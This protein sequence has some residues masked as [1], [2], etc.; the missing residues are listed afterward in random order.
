MEKSTNVLI[1]TLNMIIHT[2]N[3]KLTAELS[4]ISYLEKL[5]QLFDLKL[6]KYMLLK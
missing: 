1:L 6:C 5:A 3:L 2:Q 4:N